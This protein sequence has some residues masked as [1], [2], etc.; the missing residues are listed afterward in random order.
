LSNSNFEG[1][2]I[3][4]SIMHDIQF[5]ETKLNK[6]E[7]KEVDFMNSNFKLAQ[8]IECKFT[9]CKFEDV[10]LELSNLSE[11]EIKEC[12]FLRA[13]FQ[14]TNIKGANFERC[15]INSIK[16]WDQIINRDKDSFGAPKNPPSDFLN[17]NIDIDE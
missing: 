8:M 9:N 12:D 10:D 17:F 7:A 11:S 16:N 13:N 5:Y 15:D 1:A 2:L 14:S 3:D 6:I 4:N